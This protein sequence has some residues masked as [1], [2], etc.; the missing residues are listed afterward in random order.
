MNRPLTQSGVRLEPISPSNERRAVDYL[1]RSPYVNVF[2]TYLILHDAVPATR[3][4]IW[5]ALDGGRV[6]GAIYFGR[7]LSLACDEIAL[8]P[9]AREARRHR[10]ERMIIGERRTVRTFWELIREWHQP[11]RLLRDR[12]LVM[13]L[14]R[15]R[16]RPY[17]RTVPVRHARGDEWQAVATS[18]ALLIE[19]ELSYD[20]RR[21]G[22]DFTENVRG[23]IE[24]K[25]WW[26]GECDARLCFFC[27]IGPW[28]ERTAQ[29][30]GIWTPP[31]LRRLG[32]AAS[33]FGGICDRLLDTSPTLSL[34][35]N[36]FNEPAI[37]LY[38]RTGFEHVANF[39]TLLF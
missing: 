18:S 17:E 23:M 22:A 25:L 7:Q 28:C 1:S 15:K 38:Q 13:I 33:A 10:G 2:L 27:N 26:V 30:Q 24:R 37:A 16:L 6:C 29:L 34:Y 12:Q 35:V 3:Q 8:E 14:D 9:I 5:I 31:D 11:P 4:R 32:L 36:D 20:P 39:Q 21:A 19:Q